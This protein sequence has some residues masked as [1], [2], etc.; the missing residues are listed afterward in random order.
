MA[1]LFF[2]LASDTVQGFYFALLQYRHIQ[3]FTA[4]FPADCAL[5][6]ANDT[7]PTQAAIIP[8]VQR[9][10]VSQRRST[11]SAYKIPPPRR[12]L[13]RPAQSPYYNKVYKGAPPVMDPCQ[14]VQ[15]TT[16][17]TSPAHLLSGQRLHLHRVSPAAYDLAP[18]Q[19]SECAG[20]P[21]GGRR[22][23]IGGSRRISFRAVAR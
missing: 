5:L 23:T 10:S 3:A 18:G 19:Q 7:R 8:P 21:G 20:Q 2:C 22:G 4:A 11:S 1:G 17:Y 15:C 14:I 9:W 12:T 16:D 13:Y 6:T